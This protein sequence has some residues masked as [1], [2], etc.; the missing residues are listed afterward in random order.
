MT[1]T[2]ICAT[3]SSEALPVRGAHP[4][5][6]ASTAVLS[7]GAQRMLLATTTVEDFDTWI[8]AFEGR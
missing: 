3:L 8:K 5:A 7:S 4:A 2:T 1:S 6:G